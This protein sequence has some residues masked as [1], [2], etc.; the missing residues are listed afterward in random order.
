MAPPA[1]APRGQTHSD[2]NQ[3]RDGTD[4]ST[5]CGT[6][7]GGDHKHTGSQQ[8]NRNDAQTQIHGCVHAAHS[9]GHGGECT[10]QNVDHQHGQNVLIGST[11]GKDGELLINAL[12]AH[13]EC[14]DQSNEHGGNRGEL[15]EGHL[16]ALCLQHQTGAQVDDDEDCKRQQR[17]AVSFLLQILIH[18]C[19]LQKFLF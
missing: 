1:Q 15:V 19:F 9:L 18:V 12:L 11:L 14:K 7:E 8:L 5:G 13:A 4:R 10:G 3:C 2:G 16:H 17:E 6:Q